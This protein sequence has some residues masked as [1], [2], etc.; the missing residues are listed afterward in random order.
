ME[1][2]EEELTRYILPMR[3][4][5]SLPLL[6]EAADGF[7]YV[8]KMRGAGHGKKALIS[9]L[10][11]GL[12][13]K[14]FKFKT[15]ELVLL[16][17]DS[18]F[19]ITEPDEEVQ[20]LLRKSEGLNLGMHFLDG[21]AT[22]DPAVNQIDELTASKLVWL[23]AFLTNVD[24]TRLNPNMMIWHNELWLIDHGASLYFHHS[25]KDPEKAALDPFPYIS[26]H[27]LLPFATRLEEADALMRQAITPRTL[28]KIVDLIPEEWLEEED[29]E[30][31]AAQRREGYRMFL[32]KRLAE[33]NIFTQEAIRQRNMLK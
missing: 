6:G 12:V 15:P 18:A 2:R 19:G 32:I 7:R 28:N 30:I 29:S 4:G 3:E 11:G 27:A 31:S 20:E 33:S 24:R 14:A 21:A 13:A 17:L 22:F 25:W 10:V 16:N 1:L 23:D 8:I 9:E 5:G 26:R